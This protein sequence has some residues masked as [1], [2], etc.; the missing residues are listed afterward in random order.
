MQMRS[1]DAI[2]SDPALKE[3]VLNRIRKVKS[4]LLP[5]LSLLGAK[6]FLSRHRPGNTLSA[7]EKV[8]ESIILLIGRPVL[9]VLHG[10][11]Q[12][13]ESEEWCKKLIKSRSMLETAIRSVGR[14]EAVNVPGY[15][16]LGTAWIARDDVIVT[17]AHVARLFASKVSDGKFEFKQNY[18]NERMKAR[19][20]TREEIDQAEEIE[21]LVTD[22]LY[23]SESEKSDLAFL[24]VKRL[25][26]DGIELPQAIP[27]SDTTI[28]TPV[29]IA[30][31]GYPAR[32][33]RAVT[34]DMM[35]VFGDVYDVKRISLG[36]ASATQWPGILRHDCSTL[37]GNSGSPLIDLNTGRVLG[38]HFCG[39]TTET[40]NG[41]VSSAQIKKVLDNL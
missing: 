41:A 21:Y 24:R 7:E 32:D 35:Q 30:V 6:D 27:I 39:G 37:G 22:V 36:S 26:E 16:W 19:L 4:N 15:E 13:P 40:G 14:I 29:D 38:I 1:I 8:F 17:N 12:I 23:I 20:D 28:E 34:T 31:I 25:S 33:S 11:F 2:A 9:S 10:T 5:D 3:D 18:R